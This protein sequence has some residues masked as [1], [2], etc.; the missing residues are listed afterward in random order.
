MKQ[1][2]DFKYTAFISYR[3]VEPDA[4]IAAALHRAIETFKVPKEFYQDGK[5][6]TFRVFRDREE[7]SAKD[8]SDSI[9]EALETSYYLIVISSKRTPLS[10]WCTREV[11]LFRKLHGDDRIISVLIEGEPHE[12]FSQPLKDLH[13]TIINEAGEEYEEPRELLAA[14]LRPEAIKG[15][16][17]V[18]YEK[19][20]KDNPA[21]ADSY[22]KEALKLLKTEIFRI[23]A[24][25]L[26]C[27]Y[28]DLKQRDK[29]RRQRQIIRVSAFFSV[30]FLAFGIF[31]FR[32]YRQEN[33]ARR[34]A[35]QTN[36]TLM[37]NRSQ[38]L[39][40]EGDKVKAL[41]VARQAMAEIDTDMEKYP[42]LKSQHEGILSEALYPVSSSIRTKQATGNSMTFIDV[43]GDNKLI[44]AGLDN[45][46]VGLFDTASGQLMKRLSG[47]KE[48]VK[49][50]AFSEDGSKLISAGFDDTYQL[51]DVSTGEILKTMSHPGTPMMTQFFGNDEFFLA[52]ASRD[53]ILYRYSE[54]GEKMQ[55]LVLDPFT[56][57][58]KYDPEKK[59]ILTLAA[60]NQME[61]IRRY[62]FSTE[63]WLNN[64]PVPDIGD[65]FYRFEMI[66]FA[67]DKDSFYAS[68]GGQLFK[69]K[70]DD[71]E[72]LWQFENSYYSNAMKVEEKK[73]G[74]SFFL[75][76]NS[77]LEE[78]DSETGELLGDY[79][80]SEG[81]L[82]DIAYHDG[83]NTVA[84]A[85]DTGKVAF[86]RDGSIMD[87]GVDLRGANADEMEFSPDG[88]RLF[89]NSKMTKEILILDIPSRS[90][91][92]PIMAQV[93]GQSTLGNSALM[94]NGESFEVWDTA[95]KELKYNIPK[96]TM[97]YPVSYL[98]D[99]SQF[100]LSEDGQWVAYT[101][102]VI[103]NDERTDSLWII[104][105][106]TLEEKQI[107]LD[108]GDYRVF[109]HP[110]N[111]HLFLVEVD[112]V[113][114]L[115]LDGKEVMSLEPG[116]STNS[117][118]FSDTGN[119][120]GLNYGQGNAQVF[121]MAT[122]EVVLDVPGEILWL[123]DTTV[124]GIYNRSF[125]ET[126]GEAPVYRELAQALDETPVSLD[127][128][129]VYHE[130]SKQL[131]II[132]NGPEKPQ[133]FLLDVE[134]GNLRRRFE[135][136]L[137]QY[138][139]SGY[140]FG[141]GELV[142]DQAYVSTI[143]VDESF[144]SYIQSLR[145]H[146]GDYQ[147]MLTAET[148]FLGNRELSPEERDELGLEK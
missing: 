138:Q 11:E 60:N 92:E 47:H 139:A 12:S 113:R 65:G 91:D 58:L 111:E 39:I 116:G 132:R 56:K 85:L 31:M 137:T 79:F 32:A 146:F 125:F 45:D 13:K 80:F 19:L 41:L 71:G 2:S 122:K 115:D 118:V 61:Q 70:L 20:Q 34:E 133:A 30:L 100:G 75:S 76:N 64:V 109:F 88:L 52:A 72:V 102:Y 40:S 119:R 86:W 24:A 16:G 140:F 49:L 26:G 69:M 82:T 96:D 25:I 81:I 53:M 93:A 117:V 126:T 135:L 36:S 73:D 114:M 51:W 142:L 57:A 110:D 67:A 55:E 106:N 107:T 123:D 99:L 22:K 94:F 103:S 124:R 130:P 38:D 18:G 147:Q 74:T 48:Q 43:S 23:M 83:T 50:V 35:L 84:A 3:H 98:L 63:K 127:D 8:L 112:R 128:V 97:N 6:P 144:T 120:V 21:L 90:T 134:T 28:G 15:D 104:N 148:E 136:P 129:H 89:V 145:F 4:T 27:S 29:E 46:S 78:R 131:L 10:D 143:G 14:D 54:G 77:K 108:I 9:Q 87:S 5:H 95:A 1:L 101:D 121:D 66:E 7:L 62:D 59:Q 68:R 33:I 141:D 37:L 105:A 42:A 17:F 44:A